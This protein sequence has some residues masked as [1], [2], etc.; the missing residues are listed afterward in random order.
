MADP[1]GS[2]TNAAG[3]PIFSFDIACPQCEY[4][5]RG[6]TIC[7][8]PECGSEFDP[9]D[10]LLAHRDNQPPLPLWWVMRTMYRHPWTFW[11]MERVKLSRGPRRLQ[12][13]FGLI[14]VPILMALVGS[15][16]VL[17]LLWGRGVASFGLLLVAG[18]PF[19]ALFASLFVYM[20]CLVHGIL[21]RAGL[22]LCGKRQSV[23]AAKEVVGY[24]LIW[25]APLFLAL[26]AAS[27]FVGSLFVRGSSPWAQVTAVLLLGAA[28][29]ACV[30]WV[31]TL[32][33]GGHFASGGNGR[34]GLWCVVCHPITYFIVL[35]LIVAILR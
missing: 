23:R 31:T 3:E 5:L 12:I 33:K 9:H 15:E 25:L 21:C 34:V 26:A 22:A 11:Q 14:F 1:V 2:A 18:V 24:G 27:P 19:Q 17:S 28:V 16:V 13:F 8:C 29:A 35:W 6:L 10:V 7:R 4:N 20:L 30:A 32:Y